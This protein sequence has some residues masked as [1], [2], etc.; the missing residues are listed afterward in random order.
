M[1]FSRLLVSIIEAQIGID[2][3]NWRYWFLGRS[4]SFA[5]DA[6]T[7]DTADTSESL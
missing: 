4:R 2:A 5:A 3:W 7:E 6:S 1:E